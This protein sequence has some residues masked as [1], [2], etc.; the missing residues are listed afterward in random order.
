V[1]PLPPERFRDAAVILPLLGLFLLMPPLITLFARGEHLF[2]IPV[3]VIY[4][5]GVWL[6]LVACAALIARRLA[7]P[8]DPPAD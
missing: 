3:I 2:G 4:I 7:S 8:P 6:A 5:F 1:K